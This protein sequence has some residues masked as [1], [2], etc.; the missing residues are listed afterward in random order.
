MGIAEFQ[1]SPLNI[2]IMS[3]ISLLKKIKEFKSP[4][5]YQYQRRL[6]T[7]EEDKKILGWDDE[8][9]S[10][11]KLDDFEFSNITSKEDKKRL[12]SLLNDMNG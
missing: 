8:F 7:I 5:C 4:W 6:D 12:Q 1:Q 11:I 3:D 2:S 9:I 10:N